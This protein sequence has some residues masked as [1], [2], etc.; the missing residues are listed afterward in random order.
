LGDIIQSS[1]KYIS[2]GIQFQTSLKIQRILPE[3]FASDGAP[4]A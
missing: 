1:Q 2:V 3:R 4:P